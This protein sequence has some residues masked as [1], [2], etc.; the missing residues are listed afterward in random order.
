MCCQR[1]AQITEIAASP[2]RTSAEIWPKTSSS[3]ALG[4]A[5]EPEGCSSIKNTLPM[6]KGAALPVSSSVR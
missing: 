2:L 3:G 4:L 1:R 5:D 6:A